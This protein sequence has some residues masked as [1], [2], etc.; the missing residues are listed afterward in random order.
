MAHAWTVVSSLVR[1]GGVIALAA[2]IG[3]AQIHAQESR[4]P[5]PTAKI[6]VEVVPISAALRLADV[7]VTWEPGTPIDGRGPLA[8]R[9]YSKDNPDSARLIPLDSSGMARIQC[10]SGDASDA[11]NNV[12][13]SVV[14]W[15][16]TGPEKVLQVLTTDIRVSDNHATPDWAKGIVWYQVLPDRFHNA[17][18]LNDPSGPEVWNAP[19]TSD[20]STPSLAEHESAWLA[21]ESSRPTA[22]RATSDGLLSVIF[23][24]RYGGDLPGV[25]DRLNHLASLNVGGI[26]LC[27]VFDAPSLHKYDASDHRHIDPTLAPRSAGETPPDL[28]ESTDPRDRA[29]PATWLWS[30]AD[31]YFLR[32]FLPTVHA[33][34]MRVILD[35]VWNHTG[36]RHWAFKDLQARGRASPYAEWYRATFDGTAPDA[37]LLSF[38]G[39]D[40]R[41]GTLPAFAQTPDRDLVPPVKRHIFDITKRWMT[42]TDA[43]GL[44]IRGIDGWRLDVAPD[45]GLSFWR[46]WNALVN[47]LNPDAITIAEVWHHAPDFTSSAEAGVPRAFDAQ[48]NY[49]FARA[50]VDWLRGHDEKTADAANLARSLNT[51]LQ[52]H[53]ATNLVQMNLLASH[54]TQRL[55]SAL[56]NP[57]APYDSGGQMGR[58]APAYDRAKPNDHA[59]Q[60][61]RLALAIQVTWEGSPMICF[62][63]EFGVHGGKDPDN[64]K[65]VPWPDL[66]P[67]DNP[68]D[69]PDLGL[70]ADY[71]RWF[72]LR[73]DPSIGPVLRLGRTRTL[74]TGHPRAFAFMRQL[75]DAVA[76]V[77]VNAS[78]GG[79]PISPLLAQ[80]AES[81]AS[82]RASPRLVV[83]TS[84]SA[85]PDQAPAAPAISASVW[86]LSAQ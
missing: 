43:N 83:S 59:Y 42:P 9:A 56:A 40:A 35:G 52:Q 23:R 32:E 62:G 8:I 36:R 34:E 45:I 28:A 18:M 66:A 44:P 75:N 78:D 46:E 2:S 58:R 77:V 7:H 67:F 4:V 5:E 30:R 15:M 74:D 16:A 10:S 60:L 25:L 1:V 69:D 68:N 47:S 33:R 76:L 37:P 55:V 31:E 49:P 48:M 22:R 64:R 80:V 70:L 72:S 71:Q 61:A 3:V 11:G 57:G 65:P 6:L 20:W 79:V 73:T 41:N 17:D 86:L 26:Y 53:P 13:I 84:T 24:R 85:T 51:L 12:T 50:V 29:N 38:Q 81:G 63:D 54:D 21:R 14:T 27:P 19:W 82:G 39:W